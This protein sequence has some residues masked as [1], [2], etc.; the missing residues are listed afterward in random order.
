M[1]LE[2]A[3]QFAEHWVAAWNS[4]DVNAVLMHYADD[5]EMTTPMIQ[6]VLGIESGTLKG[7]AAV[8]DYWRA[9]LKKAPD[10]EFSIIE[11]TS[12]VGSAGIYYN[13]IMGKKAIETFFFNDAGLVYKA[14]ATYS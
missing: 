12:G 13:A 14:L 3:K 2:E 8:G 1:T 6:R 10:L 9:A 4:H 7:K 11:V 5:F